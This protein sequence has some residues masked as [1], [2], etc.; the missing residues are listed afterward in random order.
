MIKLTAERETIRLSFDLAVVAI[1]GWTDV[2]EV[3][4]MVDRCQSR[5]HVEGELDERIVAF[6]E[7]LR[8][9]FPDHPPHSYSDDSPWMST[10]LDVGIDH[11]FMSLSFGERSD[12]AIRLIRE[13]AT[14]HGLTLWDPQDGSAHKPVTP[15]SRAE[16]AAW[17]RDL[18]DGRCDR[19]ET[20]DR[21]RPWVEDSP[22]AIDDPIT[23]MGLQ[24]LH[25]FAL[26][27]DGRAGIS[28]TTRR[29]C[30][31]KAAN[32]AETAYRT[33]HHSSLDGDHHGRRRRG[34]APRRALA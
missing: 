13:L 12:P 22:A 7:R 5:V 8:A 19:A 30:R 4:A 34:A 15:P 21:A 9:R 24:Q 2:S 33:A 27:A 28:T 16:V 18:L 10:P 20:F 6:Y 29:S 25:G 1:D 17:W 26:T 32:R 23:S 14:E 11:V 3:A 31:I